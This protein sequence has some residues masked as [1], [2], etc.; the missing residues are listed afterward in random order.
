M[1]NGKVQYKDKHQGKNIIETVED[2]IYLGELDRKKPKNIDSK[3][4]RGTGIVHEILM[5]LNNVYFGSNFFE[6]LKLMRESLLISVITNQSEVW[7]STTEKEMKSLESLDSIL[8]SRA[9]QS[10]KMTSLCVMLLERDSI[11]VFTM[12]LR[13]LFH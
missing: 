1:I 11:I 3:I 4:A 9:L 8:L 6:A 7:V 2:H 10:I 13:I 5:I 12:N